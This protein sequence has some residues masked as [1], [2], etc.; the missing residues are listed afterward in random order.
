MQVQT[1]HNSL[2]LNRRQLVHSVKSR[3]EQQVRTVSFGAEGRDRKPAVPI[4]RKN[5]PSYV[6]LHL[7][8][9][10]EAWPCSAL[11]TC[12]ALPL[13]YTHFNVQG[14]WEPPTQARLVHLKTQKNIAF[15]V[16]YPSKKQVWGVVGGPLMLYFKRSLKPIKSLR[17]I[18]PWSHTHRPIKGS[19]LIHGGS[20][21]WREE[22]MGGLWVEI[23]PPGLKPRAVPDATTAGGT[24]RSSGV[25]RTLS[26]C[27][28]CPFHRVPPEVC[29]TAPPAT[30]PFCIPPV[31]AAPL[32]Q[33]SRTQRSHLPSVLT[34]AWLRLRGG[35]G[36][37]RR[38][39]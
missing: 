15:R 27:P 16:P 33:P 29:G 11:P 19:K 5:R 18:T 36:G 17:R 31:P 12:Q 23:T 28:F 14:W 7:Q 24:R 25:E 30:P 4:F 32:P 13:H 37:G 34:R 8:K 20:R 6:S 22:A 3:A 1:K 9:P 39:K 21:G 35:G 38:L 10:P 2:V 26:I